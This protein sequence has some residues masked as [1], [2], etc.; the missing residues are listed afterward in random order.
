MLRFLAIVLLIALGLP[1]RAAER[2]IVPAS[3]IVA[4]A[5]AML[6]AKASG[7]KIAAT[8][9]LVGHVGDLTVPAAGAVDIQAGEMKGPW[10]RPRVGVPVRVSFADGR[11]TPVT[12]WFS[13]TAPAQGEVYA[14][15]YARGTAAAAIQRQLGPV[16]LARMRG[17]PAAQLSDVVEGAASGEPKAQRLRRAVK[18]GAAVAAD[19]FEPMPVVQV[20]QSVRI[21]VASGV[22]KLSTKGRALSDGDIGQT[23]SVLPA[24][25]SQ[26]VRARVVSDQVVTI[27]N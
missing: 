22:V 27:E 14:A 2:Q 10:L 24:N 18:A 1:V 26:P 25:A 9:A 21:D 13:V 4:A 17:K 5:Q 8:F 3:E 12:V 23:I 15:D 19:D 7:D 20:Q 11:S 6:E 16:D